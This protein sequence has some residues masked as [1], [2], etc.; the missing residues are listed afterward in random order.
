MATRLSYLPDRI[1]SRRGAGG[2]RPTPDKLPIARRAGKQTRRLL[3]L[4]RAQTQLVKF[5]L[6]WLGTDTTAALA[7]NEN[8]FPDFTP[9]LAYYFAKETDSSCARRCSRQR[10]PSRICCSPTTRT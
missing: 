3:T 6:M 4:P 10:A 7:K 2:A 8:A 5:H 1:D 9:L